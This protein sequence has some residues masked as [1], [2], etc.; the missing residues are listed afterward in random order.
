LLESELFGHE[1]GAFTGA[2]DRRK[3]RFELADRG[4]IFLDEVGELE[5]A[6]QKKLLRVLQ[7]GQFERVGG[8]ATIQVDARV[9]AATN[10][11]LEAAVGDGRFREDLYYRLNVVRID[12]PPLRSRREDIPALAAHFLDRYREPSGAQH[13]ISQ[14][15]LE[16]LMAHPWPGNVRQLENAIHR[17]AVL[18]RGPM[19][20]VEDLELD[21][22]APHQATITLD[23]DA[24]VRAGGTMD[25][26]RA[27]AEAAAARAALRLEGGDP[28]AA[29]ARLG[30]S[31]ARLE[32]LAGT[33]T[34]AGG[35]AGDRN[36][37]PRVAASESRQAGR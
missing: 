32:I 22:P 36:E 6:T 24:L 5:P 34:G 33:G 27:A 10:I 7:L 18:A 3:G 29:A 15:A 35:D 4:T 12:L 23:V 9:I 25:A 8:Q 1:K 16:R 28:S 13:K 20:T 31:Q 30:V 37:A 26:I 21:A 17:A 14:A 11:D 2:V 19:I